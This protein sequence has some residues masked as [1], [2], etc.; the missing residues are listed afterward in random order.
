L[1]NKH[2]SPASQIIATAN[3]LVSQGTQGNSD[4]LDIYL[5]ALRNM[6]RAKSATI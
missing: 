2:C 3:S 1:V 6:D 5:E 4:F